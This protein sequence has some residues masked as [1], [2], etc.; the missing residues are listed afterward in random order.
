MHLF[1]S[2][3]LSILLYVWDAMTLWL[4]CVP[5]PFAIMILLV[6]FWEWAVG[7]DV[8]VHSTRLHPILYA[9]GR[10][11]FRFLHIHT[12]PHGSHPVDLTKFPD[13]CSHRVVRHTYFLPTHASS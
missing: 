2:W 12:S 10:W 13:A 8:T 7:S 11:E 5:K 9:P 3:Q 1:I 6:C 4:T